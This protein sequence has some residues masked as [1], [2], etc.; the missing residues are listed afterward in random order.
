VEPLLSE[1]GWWDDPEAGLAR[2]RA[3][4]AT[5]GVTAVCSQGGVIPD[6][7]GT[8]VGTTPHPTG[9]EP[10]DVPARKAS[11]WVLGFTKAGDLRSADHYPTPTG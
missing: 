3:L 7:V 11:T 6:A 9:V 4:A 8:L 2:V 10:D 1:D 5:P